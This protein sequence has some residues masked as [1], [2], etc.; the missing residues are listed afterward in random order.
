[1]P[2][3]PSMVDLSTEEIMVGMTFEPDDT[4]HEESE[5][6][7][8]LFYHL[9]R[10]VPQFPGSAYDDTS[11]DSDDEDSDGYSSSVPSDSEFSPA[12]RSAAQLS[13]DPGFGTGEALVLP[14]GAVP[15]PGSD[16]TARRSPTETLPP[17]PHHEPDLVQPGREDGNE[18][19]GRLRP[20]TTAE[21]LDQDLREGGVLGGN[22]GVGQGAGVATSAAGAAGAA[23]EQRGGLSVGDKE[24]EGEQDKSAKGTEQAGDQQ[25]GEGREG[26]SQPKRRRCGSSASASASAFAGPGPGSAD[27]HGD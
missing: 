3:V 15:L 12:P 21:E 2:E 1:M 5:R 18:R 20:R 13:N 17:A 26:E 22:G 14:P 10:Q 9:S 11:D 16:G 8:S 23:S 19:R 24:V 7:L 6:M 25:Q 4:P 27:D